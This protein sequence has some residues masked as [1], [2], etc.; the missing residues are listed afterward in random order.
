MRR[1][2]LLLSAALLVVPL[3]APAQEPPVLE[4]PIKCDFER[5]CLLQFYVDRD[6]GPGISDYRC[7]NQTYDTHRGTDFRVATLKDLEAGIEVVA[8]AAGTVRGVRDEMPDIDVMELGRDK[9]KGRAAGNTVVIDHGGGWSTSYWHMKRGSIAVRPGE[10]VEAGQRLGL[11]GLS[12]DTNFPHLHLELRLNN[13]T[14][15]DP[16]SGTGQQ[17]ACQPG[18]QGG[19][20]KPMWSA[21]ALQTL[22]YR[23]AALIQAGFS[24]AEPTRQ[25]VTY[26]RIETERLP[27]AEGKLYFFFELQGVAKGDRIA[28]VVTPPD[29]RERALYS[30]TYVGERSYV[31][32]RVDA[33]AAGIPL[34]AGRYQ[35]EIGLARETDGRRQIIVR[36]KLDA[37]LR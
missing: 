32:D 18:G 15:I 34:T 16:F 22:R 21:R 5:Q 29:G 19:S 33:A 12:G 27:L 6:P 26:N 8:A 17:T 35:A 23:P 24:A 37:E 13:T 2:A 30:K 14:V 4:L 9:V 36:E 10:R 1:F 7:G 25:A 11:V 20:A 31:F 3:A 28:I